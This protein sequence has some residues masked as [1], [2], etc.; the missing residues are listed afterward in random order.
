MARKT[1]VPPKDFEEAVRELEEILSQIERGVPLEQSLVMYERGSFLIQHC[2][3]ILNS[4]E[5][6]IEMITKNPDGTLRLERGDEATERRGDEG[7]AGK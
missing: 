4:A 1:Q 7:E 6:Q 5:K 3:A 2:T